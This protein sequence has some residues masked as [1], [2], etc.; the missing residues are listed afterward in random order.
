MPASTSREAAQA[1]NQAY[2]EISREADKRLTYLEDMLKNS[3]YFLMH[4]KKQEEIEQE[5][6]MER[7]RIAEEKRLRELQE[8]NEKAEEEERRRKAATEAFYANKAL[9][10]DDDIDWRAKVPKAKKNA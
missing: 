8:A 1:A 3:E 5:K 2:A 7:E 10:N 9:L 6:R 4:D